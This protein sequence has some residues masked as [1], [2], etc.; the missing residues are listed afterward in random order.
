MAKV[1]IPA[2][3]EGR[4]V[5]TAAQARAL[6]RLASEKRGIPADVLMENAGRAVAE[7]TLSFLKKN[8]TR[9]AAQAR[10]V[11]CC[12]RGANGGDGLVAA[13]HLARSGVAV[14]VFLCP[15]KK[16]SP[17]PELVRANLDRAREAGVKIT[18]AGEQAGLAQALGQADAALDALLGTGSSGKPAGAVHHMIAE[19]TRAKKPV[20]S[21]DL[22][23][24]LHPDTGY[25]SG[26]YV[27]A[28]LT[29]T[30]GWAKRGLLTAHSQRYVGTLKV[31]DIGYPKDLKP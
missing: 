11:V 17:Y 9:E 21:I 18:A 5:V 23:S 24:G 19:L 2:V 26:V 20:I 3:Y 27:T 30:L 29:L 4:P 16:D 6:D 13:R 28:A 10:V 15:A 31:L 25:H 22:P 8:L 1:E 12:G 14:S 7:E